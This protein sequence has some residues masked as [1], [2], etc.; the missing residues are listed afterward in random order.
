MSE[1]LEGGGLADLIRAA[2]VNAKGYGTIPKAVMMDRRLTVCAKAIY[3]YFCSFCGAGSQAFPHV[4]KI[5]RDMQ[6]SRNYYYRS[7]KLL[8]DYDYV[9]V[10]QE[11][12]SGKFTRNIYTIVPCPSRGYT[13][14][15]PS[16]TPT[17]D[18]VKRDAYNN[19]TKNNNR[20]DI[21][22]YPSKKKHKGK[23]NTKPGMMDRID[24]Y[25]S[26]IK[27]N[28]DYDTLL[29]GGNE[30][31]VNSIVATIVDALVSDAPT[32]RISGTDMN[33]AVVKERLLQLDYSDIGCILN[34][35]G[36]VANHV[37]NPKNYL[38]TVLYNAP[39]TSE[40][41]WQ[42]EITCTTRDF[43]N[44]GRTHKDYSKEIAEIEKRDT[45]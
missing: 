17:G 42:S 11:R 39:A 19:N 2:G 34:S 12:I 38:L 43:Y 1:K 15:P 3:A 25:T 44:S 28:I 32:L 10:E 26:L 30:K 37:R 36:H 21:L 18:T 6:I 27:K 40:M 4:G 13:V 7:L 45:P 41:F 33:A 16:C 20:Y 5:L 8:K 24:R 31:F 22:S 35:M 9:R 14:K 23:G 29:L